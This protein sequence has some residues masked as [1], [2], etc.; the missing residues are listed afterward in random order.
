[1]SETMMKLTVHCVCGTSYD[2]TPDTSSEDA[3]GLCPGCG[4]VPPRPSLD[5]RAQEA[6]ELEERALADFTGAMESVRSKLASALSVDPDTKWERLVPAA[7]EL[8]GEWQEVTTEIDSLRFALHMVREQVVKADKLVWDTIGGRPPGEAEYASDLVES[9]GALIG[10]MEEGKEVRERLHTEIESLE[11]DVAVLRAGDETSAG[12]WKAHFLDL[13]MAVGVPR[14]AYGVVTAPNVD[15][16][17]TYVGQVMPAYKLLQRV[18]ELEKRF[19]TTAAPQGTETGGLNRVRCP[20]CGTGY[21]AGVMFCPR[22]GKDPSPATPEGCETC[23][24]APD[25]CYPDPPG[26]GSCEHHKPKGGA[27]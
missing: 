18:D 22:C 7:Q 4:G 24:D 27:S 5:E 3:P 15:A 16:V 25:D 21:P 6:T 11:E 12:T 14:V 9:V 17:M 2:I 1:M 19:N 8:H 26:A 13:A 20:H 23:E 10:K